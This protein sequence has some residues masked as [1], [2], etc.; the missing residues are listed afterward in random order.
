MVPEEQ[1][2]R[3]TVRSCRRCQKTTCPGNSDIL[4]CPE[5]C[6]VPCKTCLR[7]EGCRGVDKGR[8]CTYVAAKWK[9]CPCISSELGNAD[10][11]PSFLL[12]FYFW[13]P[14]LWMENRWAFSSRPV[15]GPSMTRDIWRV[16]SID[17]PVY[18][19]L[20]PCTAH[21]P[22]SFLKKLWNY[23][24]PW[25]DF[26][27]LSQIDISKGTK[28]ILDLQKRE[29][30]PSL[31]VHIFPSFFYYTDDHLQLY[32]PPT[33]SNLNTTNFGVKLMWH[34][35]LI[36]TT[37]HYGGHHTHTHMIYLGSLT[38]SPPYHQLVAPNDNETGSNHW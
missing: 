37:T 24:R 14:V 33:D 21:F 19:S 32:R 5:P 26:T 1:R 31:M 7:T 9:L 25:T 3:T 13:Y 11:S 18:L 17:R 27:C 8:K 30:L 22:R 34:T 38:T 12:F 4:K 15:T 10:K 6:A 20:N 23:D 36:S 16:L 35:I 28:S 2:K 29:R